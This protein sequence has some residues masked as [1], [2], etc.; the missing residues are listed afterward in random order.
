MQ[1]AALRA[2]E[3]GEPVLSSWLDPVAP[4][5]SSHGTSDKDLV[6]RHSEKCKQLRVAHAA[7]NELELQIAQLHAIGPQ[8]VWRQRALVAEAVDTL[9]AEEAASMEVSFV[10]EA[11]VVASPAAKSPKSTSKSPR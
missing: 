5:A 6:Q 9:V 1:A 2:Y 7:R 10:E 11:P 4:A 3:L 8:A